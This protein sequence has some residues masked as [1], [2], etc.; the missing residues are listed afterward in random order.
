MNPSGFRD[1]VRKA[2]TGDGQA[3]DE[4]F[5]LAMPFVERVIHARPLR[6]GESI[7]DR[8]QNVCQ[9]ILTKLDQFRG[10]PEAPDDEQTWALF[11]GWVRQIV[12]TVGINTD[13]GRDPQPPMRFRQAGDSTNQ[14]GID[15]PITES[16]PTA[17]ARRN[18]EAEL[19]LAALER[20]PDPTN[21]EIV[22]LR[23]FDGLSLREITERLSLTYDVVRERYRVSMR[24]LRREL[25][26]LE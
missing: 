8:R 14:G 24:R 9:R 21:R 6:T 3:R 25:E 16:T 7:S 4:L 13:R 19:I 26:G 5:R 15:P 20:L 22:R 10:A 12:F 1:L 23:F 17:H 18:E 11:S 2:Q